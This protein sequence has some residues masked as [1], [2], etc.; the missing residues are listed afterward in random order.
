MNI[1]S[2]GLPPR[3][4]APNAFFA[5][6]TIPVQD[7]CST[8]YR[9]PPYTAAHP[10]LLSLNQTNPEKTLKAA[11]P[12]QPLPSPPPNPLQNPPQLPQQGAVTTLFI[13]RCV[14]GTLA[15]SSTMST[16]WQQGSARTYAGALVVPGNILYTDIN[17]YN[18]MINQVLLPLQ[19]RGWLQE[20][21]GCVWVL[22]FLSLSHLPPLPQALWW[23]SEGQWPL[24]LCEG[25]LTT[26]CGYLL[27]P[28]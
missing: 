4:I 19:Q 14:T 8:E 10:A 20:V 9:P 25:A 16:W 1:C 5:Q 28:E 21:Q 27:I 6:Q 17:L 12:P 3:I 2:V 24:P 13:T 11:L 22:L 26:W 23:P 7:N 18:P 15:W